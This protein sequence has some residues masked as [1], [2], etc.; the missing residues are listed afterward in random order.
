[1]IWYHYLV[2]FFFLFLLSRKNKS[3]S[4]SFVLK[5]MAFERI[6]IENYKIEGFVIKVFKYFFTKE[7]GFWRDEKKY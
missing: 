4:L 3:L 7:E 5:L 6:V 2:V 1:M